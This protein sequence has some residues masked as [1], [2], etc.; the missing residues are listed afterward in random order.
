MTSYF[1][2]NKIHNIILFNNGNE[3]IGVED[4]L[5]IF[6]FAIIKSQPNKY[7]SNFKYM[8]MYL[9]KELINSSFGHILSQINLTG[10]FIKNINYNSLFNV[11]N[12]EFS[13]KCNDAIVFDNFIE[14]KM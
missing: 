2:I 5:P 10:E 1:G 12:D 13:R 11:T 4:S 9:N 3:V 14:Q 6:Q 7:N 8:N